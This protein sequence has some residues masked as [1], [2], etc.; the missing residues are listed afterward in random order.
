AADHPALMAFLEARIGAAPGSLRIVEA[1]D[2]AGVP[3]AFADVPDPLLSIVG[4]ASL[5]DLEQAVGAPV[6][7]A[8][9]RANLWVGDL[10]AWHEFDWEGRHLRIGD[11][12]VRVVAPITRCAAI[13]AGASG[14][15]D[16]PLL[17]TLERHFRHQEC[18]VYAEVVR[19]GPIEVGYIVEVI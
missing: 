16:L 11:A 7:A 8:R 10:P 4:L 9:L 3:A 14:N 19:G 13:D 1:V 12:E 6:D 17:A 2:D 5:R 15:R 18:G